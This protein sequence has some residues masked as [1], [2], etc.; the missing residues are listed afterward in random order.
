MEDL[1]KLSLVDQGQPEE[2]H[3]EKVAPVSFE[4]VAHKQHKWQVS[5]VFNVHTFQ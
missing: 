1:A 3:L 5:N 4:A 2:L